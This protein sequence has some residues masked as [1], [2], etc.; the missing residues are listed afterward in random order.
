MRRILPWLSLVF[1]AAG[2]AEA[3]SYR[4]ATPS[5]PCP[6]EVLALAP[7]QA[8]WVNPD[9]QGVTCPIS[10]EIFV[11][12]K[13]PTSALVEL[14]NLL[15]EVVEEVLTCQ[16]VRP[17]RLAGQL[18]VQPEQAGEP[19][20]LALA[21]A[22]RKVKAEAVLAGTIFRWRER[23]GTSFG[24]SEPASVS[25]GL[26]LIDAKDGAIRWQAFFEETQ[27][28]LS[29]NLLQAG[30]FLKRGGRWLTAAELSRSGI[31]QLLDRLPSRPVE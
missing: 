19:I 8:A 2:C 22:T 20:R 26:Y 29:E 24:V 23:Q 31:I 27:R 4:P 30:A 17:S 9:G 6:V 21:Q 10:G 3:P 1:L 11:G 28:S 15:P 14:S 5:R 12:E 7:F 18:P 13:V 25:L 16:V